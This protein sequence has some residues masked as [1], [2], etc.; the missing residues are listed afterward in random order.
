MKPN[1]QID[2]L[3]TSPTKQLSEH[4]L[5]QKAASN[6]VRSQIET[7]YAKQDNRATERANITTQ[8]YLRKYHSAWQDYYQKYYENYY[9]E[10]VKKQVEKIK[11]TG[12]KTNDKRTDEEIMEELKRD[13]FSKINKRS[14]KIRRSRHFIPLLAGFLTIII[15]LFLQYNQIITAN[16]V[17]FISP[18][19]ISTQNIIVNP[20]TDVIVSADPRLIIPKI[21]V[22]VPVVYDIGSD[23]DSQMAAMT[24]GVAQFSIP[25]ADSHPGQIGNTVIAGHSSNDLFDTGDYKFIFAQLDRLVEGDTIYI[26]YQS[27]R[28]TY[29]VTSK[30]VVE[31]TDI[32]KVAIATDKPLLTLVTCTPLGTS[33]Y[34]LLIKAEQINPDPSKAR[35]IT[36]TATPATSATI[37]GAT[38][39]IFQKIFNF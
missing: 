24:K 26:N 6:A 15:F 23:Y 35:T 27:I 28:Y 3:S 38:K 11:N 1:K 20:N 7:I 10:H 17:A 39:S 31:P 13:L 34:R 30:E 2:T 32:D 18:G 22:D 4:Q 16:I 36:S 5:T 29:S 37:P 25:G 33:R 8:E 12:S 21:N 19:N 14:K 9:T